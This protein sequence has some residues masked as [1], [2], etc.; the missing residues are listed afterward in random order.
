M[1][2][3]M[4]IP[5]VITS[6]LL[7]WDKRTPSP[8]GIILELHTTGPA[9][10]RVGTIPLNRRHVSVQNGIRGKSIAAQQ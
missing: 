1:A 5:H 7:H 10:A 9:V 4:A 2:D 3:G 6:E 8:R